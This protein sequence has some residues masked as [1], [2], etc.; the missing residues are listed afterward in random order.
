LYA[1]AQS[2]NTVFC[3]RAAFRQVK[4]PALG[5]A[6]ELIDFAMDLSR[7]EIECA[8]K[9]FT[10]NRYKFRIAKHMAN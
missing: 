4:F 7:I 3:R 10:S 2:E 1:Q 8:R 9:E 6:Q 5:Q